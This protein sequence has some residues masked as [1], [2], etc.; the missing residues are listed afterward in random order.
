MSFLTSLQEQRPHF[1]PLKNYTNF[2]TPLATGSSVTIDFKS[3]I[4]FSLFSNF[5]NLQILLTKS[6][7]LV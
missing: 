4:C 3:Q 6:I 7:K 2:E 1:F 5:H